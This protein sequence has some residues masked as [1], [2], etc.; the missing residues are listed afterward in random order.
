[1]NI[2]RTLQMEEN[3]KVIYLLACYLGVIFRFKL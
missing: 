1:M 2:L 3:N